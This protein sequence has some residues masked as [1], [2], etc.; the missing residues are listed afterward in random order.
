[1]ARPYVRSSTWWPTGDLWFWALQALVTY[2]KPGWTCWHRALQ[3]TTA[4]A[5]ERVGIPVGGRGVDLGCGGGHVTRQLGRLVSEA[6]LVVGIDLDPRAV[7]LAREDADLDG[8]DNVEFRVADVTEFEGE[9]L[10]FVFARLVLCHLPNAAAVIDQAVA[11]LRPGGL[12]LVEEPDFS[13]CF[14]WPQNDAYDRC[15]VLQREVIRSRGGDPD[16]GPKLAS[17]FLDVGLRDVEVHVLQ[18]AFLEAP[19]KDIPHVSLEKMSDAIV[20][21]ALAS[22]DELDDLIADVRVLAA[23]ERSLL[24][25]P[26]FFQVSGRR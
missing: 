26:R 7:E 2:A 14:S 9:G 3:P 1:V 23:D 20:A 24:S 19:F 11:A 6:G 4:A 22:A 8:L 12:L 18:P 17:M 10:D 25:Y 5:L 16:L 21:E 13:A 15:M